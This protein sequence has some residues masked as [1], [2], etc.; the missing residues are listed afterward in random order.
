[1]LDGRIAPLR[2]LER[3]QEWIFAFFAPCGG[4]RPLTRLPGDGGRARLLRWCRCCHA[5]AGA[6]RDVDSDANPGVH[7][8][9]V[10]ERVARRAPKAPSEHNSARHRSSGT[11]L[12]ALLDAQ[13]LH[14]VHNTHAA[15]RPLRG[16]PLRCER[17]GAGKIS[18]LS[19]LPP[20]NWAG[21]GSTD[22]QARGGD[23]QLHHVPGRRCSAVSRSGQQPGTSESSW[24]SSNG[25]G[26]AWI[27]AH[28]T[29]RARARRQGTRAAPPT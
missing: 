7:G 13:L 18:S 23:V 8:E 15:P 25:W 12:I 9:L 24:P 21:I 28:D 3:Q 27:G 4:G 14:R 6:M 20:L 26:G 29:T 16:A 11:S 5:S 17:Q 1:M 10:A 2:L 19:P 22:C